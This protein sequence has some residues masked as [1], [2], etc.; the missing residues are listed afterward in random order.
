MNTT[1]L[2][3]TTAKIEDGCIYMKKLRNAVNQNDLKYYA[4]LTDEIDAVWWLQK[5]CDK[6]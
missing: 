2:P 1:N 4:L 5:D 6:I 3:D